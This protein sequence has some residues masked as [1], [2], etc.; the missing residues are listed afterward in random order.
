MDKR[1]EEIRKKIAHRVIDNDVPF[2]V[3][4]D[5]KNHKKLSEEEHQDIEAFKDEIRKMKLFKAKILTN[6]TDANDISNLNM[7]ISEPTATVN[8]VPNPRNRRIDFYYEED[9][10]FIEGL[11]DN[12]CTFWLSKTDIADTSINT[13]ICEHILHDSFDEYFSKNKYYHE[14]HYLFKGSIFQTNDYAEVKWH[15]PF[16][17]YIGNDDHAGSFIAKSLVTF[18]TEIDKLCEA[19]EDAGNYLSIMQGILEHLS[20][21]TDDPVWDYFTATPWIKIVKNED[22]L[23]CSKN[24]QIKGLYLQLAKHCSDLYNRYMSAVR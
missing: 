17:G 16:G 1:R 15:T 3:P 22:Y 8:Y 7:L 12:N 20:Q 5:G 2:G 13:Q 18:K 23:L 19:R 10:V 24:E 4:D 9:K 21:R 11:A 14:L 6:N